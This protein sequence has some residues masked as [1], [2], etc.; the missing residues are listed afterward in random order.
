MH[1][2]R[3]IK[4]RLLLSFIFICTIIVAYL[5]LVVI[6]MP[7]DTSDLGGAKYYSTQAYKKEKK[8]SIDLVFFGNSDVYAGVSPIQIY[9]NSGISSF[10]CAS[11]KE[12]GYSLVNYVK[13]NLERQNPKLIVLDADCFYYVNDRIHGFN[14]QSKV[15][16]IAPF[17]YHARWKELE[18]K[19]FYTLP[20]PKADPLKGYLPNFGTSSYKHKETFMNN[21]SAAPQEIESSVKKCIKQIQ[22]LCEKENCALMFMCLPTPFSWNNAKSNGVSNFARELNVPFL[23]LNDPACELGLDFNNSY[24]DMGN[25]L[26]IKGA[27]HVTNFLTSYILEHYT[28]TD[29]RGEEDYTSWDEI[30]ENYQYYLNKAKQ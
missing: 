24:K 17:F 10:V 22:K 30:V 25:H 26:N 18:A 29:H 21:P 2:G 12:T 28:L 16:A 27:E 9:K 11:P 4:R 14:I 23:D 8:N 7:K 13:A 20:L 1:K 5:Y 6:F 15:M 19:D 3:L